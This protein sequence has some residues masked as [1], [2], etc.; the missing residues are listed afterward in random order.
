[1]S[2]ASSRDIA[3]LH[4]E[5]A[6]RWVLSLAEYREVHPNDPQPFLTQT[7]RSPEDQAADY[8]KGRTA[9]G[10]PV[11]NAQPMQSLHNYY[12][13][14]AFDIAFK[15]AKGLLHWEVSLFRNFGVIAKG[16]GLAWGGDW[17][18]SK[19]N[20]HFEPPNFTYHDAQA[21]KEPNFA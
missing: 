20:P 15:D 10:K 16:H 6:A 5:L 9:P 8:A 2:R 17:I 1:M 21:G 13:A 14:L 4:H 11:T 19:D 18:H 7:Y 3:D 12:P